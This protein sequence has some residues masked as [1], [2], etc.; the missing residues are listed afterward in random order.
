MIRL[1]EENDLEGV[2]HLY[3]ELRPYDPDIQLGLARRHW[4]EMMDDPHCLIIVAIID[5]QVVSSCSLTLNRS[6]ANGAKPFAIIEHVITLNNFR[7]RGLSRQV[8]NYAIETAWNH[9]CA[10]IML[11]SGEQLVGAHNLYKS[12]GF[13][14][15]VERGF[16]LKPTDKLAN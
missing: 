3:K 10:K 13:L 12:V 2:L 6:I 15:N 14:D 1:A 5:N 7:R 11:L 4:V 9:D 16:V 8:L